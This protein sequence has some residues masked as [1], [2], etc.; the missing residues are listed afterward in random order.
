MGRCNSDGQSLLGE[1]SIM[2][3]FIQALFRSLRQMDSEANT[4]MQD[5]TTGLA[6]YGGYFRPELKKPHTEPCWST[7]LSQLLPQEGFPSES[8]VQYPDIL[9]KR[10][11]CDLVASLPNGRRVW[12]EIKGAWKEYW[13]QTGGEWIY[14]SYLL[15]PLLAGLD[16]KT[17]TVPLDL[18]RLKA[19]RQQDGSDIGCLLVGFDSNEAPMDAD[20]EELQKLAGLSGKPWLRAMTHWPDPYRPDCNIRIWFWH[21]PVLPIL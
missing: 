20:I 8:S 14:R 9:P 4:K 1:E 12:I 2:E 19:V 15:H 10:R 11:R 6:W 17:H 18:E 5:Y 21:R 13:R 16:P 7:R 3:A